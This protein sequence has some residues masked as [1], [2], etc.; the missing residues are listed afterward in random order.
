MISEQDLQRFIRANPTAILLVG[1]D[2]LVVEAN[3]AASALLGRPMAVLAG[4]PIL[5]W[6]DEEDRERSKRHFAE[7]L[8][9]Q[10]VEWSTRVVRGN[11]SVRGVLFRVLPS[12][13][14]R[15]ND[16]LVV[17]IQESELDSDVRSE[18]L[19]LQSLMENLP[20]HFVMIIDAGGR[21]R[22]SGGLA[23]ALWHDDQGQVGRDFESLLSERDE[24][25]VRYE[26]FRRETADGRRW[27]GVVWLSRADGSS[28]PVQIYAAPYRGTRTNAITGTLFVGRDAS[29]EHESRD[30]FER[31]KRF[32]RIGE[33]VVSIARELGK[34]V[35][36]LDTLG[37]RLQQMADDPAGPASKLGAEITRLDH[38][39]S[40]L[41]AFSRDVVVARL[42][43]AIDRLLAE[44]IAEQKQLLA[45]DGI[46]LTPSIT[47]GLPATFLDASHIARV[48]R[49]LLENAREALAGQA[50]GQILLEAVPAAAGVVIR[51]R[52]N[53]RAGT[54]DWM[55]HGFDPFFTTKPDHLGLG[56]SLARGIV[57]EHGGQIWAERAANGWTTVSFEL[58]HE[59]PASTIV[60]RSVPLL[61]GRSRPVLVVDDDASVR[62]VLRKLL[63]RVGY[64]VSE[65]WSGRS[66]LAQI[67]SG[68]PPELV[69]TGL[70]M[71]D[72][73]GHWLLEQL[74][75]DFPGILRRTVIVT[76]DPAQAAVGELSAATGCPVLRKPVDF[77]VLLETLDEVA[78]RR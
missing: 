76:A 28:I 73:T 38:L 3:P 44:A 15:G 55:K 2:G 69:I 60:F 65:G 34:P 7:A 20:G 70:R 33:L 67:T 77:Q 14:G 50:D 42:P 8:R 6:I 72:G 59:P 23:R 71:Q 21:I 54:V 63:E 68:H 13:G 78:L 18:A 36:R 16:S 64:R 1:R 30:A 35:A 61:L 9:G 39:L 5:R 48:L 41:L 75:K 56:L 52:D 66:A 32:S 43:V 31:A 58:P 27:D 11:G 45:E 51:V 46:R 4:A 24:N 25:P 29:L 47:S 40:T 26:A 19:Q 37:A 74:A 12:T 10:T 57:E 17:Y 53:A 49:A 62:A 22:Y